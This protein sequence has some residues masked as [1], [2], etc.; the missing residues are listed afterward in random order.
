MS[1]ASVVFP[2]P[3]IATMENTCKLLSV[4]LSLFRR[5]SSNLFFSPSLPKVPV[6][7]ARELEARILLVV[8]TLILPS[9]SRS[10][11]LSRKLLMDLSLFLTLLILSS[12]SVSRDS[13]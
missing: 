11:R 10:E 6:S 5:L 9:P 8:L 4:P 3:P 7:L 13:S 2:M 12:I 1:F